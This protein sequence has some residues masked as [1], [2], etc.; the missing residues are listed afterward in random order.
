MYTPVDYLS[1]SPKC[2]KRLSHRRQTAGLIFFIFKGR[3]VKVIYWRLPKYKKEDK[4][5]FLKSTT[6]D[7]NTCTHAQHDLHTMK[8]NVKSRPIILDAHIYV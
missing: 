8:A 5:Q 4:N 2:I 3:L 7:V 6:G 1:R